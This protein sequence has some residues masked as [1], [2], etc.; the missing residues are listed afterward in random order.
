M[1]EILEHLAGLLMFD[2]SAYA[3]V[4]VGIIVFY[5]TRWHYSSN[6]HQLVLAK[7]INKDLADTWKE[8]LNIVQ[9]DFFDHKQATQERINHLKNTKNSYWG[10]LSE[11]EDILG[12]LIQG[13]VDVL[14]NAYGFKALC[15]M[16]AS[17]TDAALGYYSMRSHSCKAGSVS[18][19]L[20]TELDGIESELREIALLLQEPVQEFTSR[21]GDMVEL[22]DSF[23]LQE[24][25]KRIMDASDSIDSL[26]REHSNTAVD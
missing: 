13:G 9:K 15:V 26:A 2:V 18:K 19:Q 11:L 16:Y 12:L 4:I 25:H 14:S 23:K 21:E 10:L 5:I 1:T 7:E 6:R 3:V 24:L 17:Y 22:I 20:E 8:K